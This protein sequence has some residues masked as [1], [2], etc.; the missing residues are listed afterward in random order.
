MQRP[1]ASV[2]IPAFNR[3]AVLFRAIASIIEQSFRDWEIIV[4]DDGSTDQTAQAVLRLAQSEPRVR[5]IRHESNRGAQAARNSGIRAARGEWIAFL[6]SDDTWVPSSL[7]VRIAAACSQ[8]VHVVHSSGFVLRFGGGDLDT[9]EVPALCGNVYR[10][11]LRAAGPMFQAL[12]VSAKAFHAIG[13]LDEAI[14]AYQEWD[15]AIRLAKQFEFAFVPEPTFV[16]DCRGR[17][18]ISKNLLR[19]AKGYEQIVRKHLR[20]IALQVGPRAVSKH[21]AWLSSEYRSAGDQRASLRCKKISYLWC[22][23]P[24]KLLGALKRKA[25]VSLS[26]ATRSEDA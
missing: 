23:T 25:A 16:Y 7:G 15:T 11:L 9:F 14:V 26:V 3:E 10:K 12:L 1:V 19:G 22:P 4:V 18:T 6:D 13:G 8:N 2:I 20:D 24:R 21:Y 5:L 17:D